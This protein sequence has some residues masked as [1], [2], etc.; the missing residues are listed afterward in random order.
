M[1][2]VKVAQVSLSNMGFVVFL[3]S[4]QDERTLPVFIGPPGGAGDCH[5]S[6]RGA[7][8]PSVDT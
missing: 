1:I 3:R 5:G 7:V 2:P 4:S 6:G 8:A